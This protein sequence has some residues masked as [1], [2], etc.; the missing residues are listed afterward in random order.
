MRLGLFV[1]S[2]LARANAAG[3]AASPFAPGPPRPPAPPSPEAAPVACHP[4]P[5]APV[6]TRR[7]PYR[8]PTRRSETQA[9]RRAFRFDARIARPRRGPGPART[10]LA[11]RRTISR[12]P[13]RGGRGRSGPPADLLFRSGGR[14]R[15]EDDQR[16]RNVAERERWYVRHRLGGRDR[17][18]AVRSERGL[19][20][21]RRGGLAR[22]PD[23]RRGHVA[24]DRWR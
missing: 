20:G 24:L 15:V 2:P 22:G 3:Y 1:C 11:A 17:G 16:G 9:E 14:R 19:R 4:R 12:R 6:G 8:V 7:S 21:S 18:G 23:E 10:P 13:R 5:Y